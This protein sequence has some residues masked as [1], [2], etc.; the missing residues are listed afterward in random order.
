M[1]ELLDQCDMP[2]AGVLEQCAGGVRAAGQRR[3]R[4]ELPGA[5]SPPI[6]VRQDERWLRLRAP[7]ARSSKRLSP[8]LLGRLLAENCE[9]AGGAKFTLADDPPRPYVSAEIPL[10]EEGA[11]LA[12][13]LPAACE[14]FRQAAQEFAAA[15]R[16]SGDGPDRA[17]TADDAA[18]SAALDPKRLTICQETNWPLDQRAGDHVAFQL[19]VPGSFCQAFAEPSGEAGLR[20]RVDLA[21]VPSAGH[22]EKYALTVLLLHASHLVRMAR[23]TARAVDSA[24]VY[25]WE[26][27]LDCVAGV[28]EVRH[29][30]SALSVACRLTAREVQASAQDESLARSYLVLRGWCS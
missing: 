9:L 28:E 26:I 17:R 23:A 6:T 20:L 16:P 12:A 15:Q 24:A 8:D 1:T 13:R 11:D 7:L 19:D 30:L 21:T 29:A 4:L 22:V 3:W 10:D 18:P 2:I 14:G 25:G 27:A 5:A